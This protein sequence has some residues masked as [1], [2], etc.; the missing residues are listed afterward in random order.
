MQTRPFGRIRGK[1]LLFPLSLTACLALAGPGGSRAAGSAVQ[2]LSCPARPEG[3]AG[4]EARGALGGAAVRPGSALPPIDA[5]RPA[6]T[7]IAT[8]ALG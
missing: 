4:A 2:G 5:D 6:R 7:E 1:A 8:F 3:G